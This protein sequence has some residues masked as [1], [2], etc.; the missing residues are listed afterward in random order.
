MGTS[1]HEVLTDVTWSYYS[2]ELN[3]SEF[4]DV[5]EAIKTVEQ[6]Y[7]HWLLGE[8]HPDERVWNED[9]E[10]LQ[11]DVEKFKTDEGRK[12]IIQQN[13]DELMWSGHNA[14]Y[15]IPTFGTDVRSKIP[16]WRQ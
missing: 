16:G 15:L 8:Q 11:R 13:F 9:Q 3:L 1:M 5:I 14:S 6:N 4:H 10:A 12:K 7:R 2:E